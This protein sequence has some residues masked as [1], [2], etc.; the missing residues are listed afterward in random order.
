MFVLTSPLCSLRIRLMLDL[1]HDS[2]IVLCRILA[3]VMKLVEQLK[4]HNAKTEW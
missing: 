2:C 3:C 4:L 1:I